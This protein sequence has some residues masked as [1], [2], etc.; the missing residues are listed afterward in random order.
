M[1]YLHCS[2]AAMALQLV[3]NGSLSPKQATVLCLNRES[4]HTST[5]ITN[6]WAW[7][8]GVANNMA[9]GL[10]AWLVGVALVPEGSQEKLE[11]M[12]C[13]CI[14]IGKAAMAVHFDQGKMR[15]H[16]SK[17]FNERSVQMFPVCK[18]RRA[19]E[20]NKLKLQEEFAV[21]CFCRMPELPNILNGYNALPAAASFMWRHVWMYLPLHCNAKLFGFAVTVN[22]VACYIV[23]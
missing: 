13:D 21:H 1:L 11:P 22:S 6:V 18:L 2:D 23:L 15:R 4:L 5:L 16:L 19:T 14:S 9:L 17:C 20:S 12:I 8:V 10:W 7:F 3:Q